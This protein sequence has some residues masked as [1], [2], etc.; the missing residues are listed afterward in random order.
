MKRSLVAI[1]ALIYF[2]ISSGVVLNVHY[3]MGRVSSVK[4]DLAGAKTCACGK[5]EPKKC[6]KTELKVFK[7]EDTQ[8]A[9]FASYDIQAPVA[10]ITNETGIFY[11]PE[12]LSA[13]HQSHYA[14][15][16]PLLSAQDTYLRNGVFR[17]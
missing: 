5:S 7:I 16:P 1:L 15:S 13:D 12:Y 11:L 2:A 17:I 8:K 6:C 10:I 3:C 4:L 14:H 9:A